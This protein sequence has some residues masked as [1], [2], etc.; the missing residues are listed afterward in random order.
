MRRLFS[1]Y[2]H[3]NDRRPYL[4]AT[5]TGGSLWAYGNV[6][7]Q[8]FV[9]GRR[10]WGGGTAPSPRAVAKEHV[11]KA[12]ARRQKVVS[13]VQSSGFD[14]PRLFGCIAYGAIVTG[15]FSVAYYK[16]L[17]DFVHHRLHF[18][19]GTRQLVMAKLSFELLAWEP[20]SLLIF[21]TWIAFCQGSS[22]EDTK[23]EL[24]NGYPYELCAAWAVWLP[25]QSA[26]FYY[27]PLKYQVLL[28]NLGCIAESILLSILQ[29]QNRAHH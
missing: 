22:L 18:K 7:E 2:S 11:R 8:M 15:C 5:I 16:W 6:L 10:P 13:K 24:K 26:N 14:W 20:L 12:L 9:E 3:F 17:D 28:V 21:V 29:H 23:Q 1:K 25:V 4:C 27:V 19:H